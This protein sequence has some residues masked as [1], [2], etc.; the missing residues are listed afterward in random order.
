MW[1]FS[2]LTDAGEPLGA[3]AA[4]ADPGAVRKIHATLST[5]GYLQP[6]DAIKYTAS[7]GRCKLDPSLKATC[8]QSLNLRVHTVLST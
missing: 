2:P 5:A 3:A 1:T 4:A 8:F 6:N 7:V